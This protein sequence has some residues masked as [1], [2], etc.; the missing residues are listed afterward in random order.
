MTSWKSLNKLSEQNKNKKRIFI[1]FLD[2]DVD[3]L[4]KQKKNSL[5]TKIVNKYHIHE[6]TYL[7]CIIYTIV[8]KQQPNVKIFLVFYLIIINKNFFFFFG[9]WFSSNLNW[10]GKGN[11]FFIWYI[12]VWVSDIVCFRSIL[13]FLST[14]KIVK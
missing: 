4:I 11:L 13:N 7:I 5:K 3:Y 2:N 12:Y 8:I 9:L 1:E 6:F 14:W 10:I